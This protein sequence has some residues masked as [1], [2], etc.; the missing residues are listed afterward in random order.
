LSLLLFSSFFTS[1]HEFIFTPSVLQV[2][3][4]REVWGI[5]DEP[6]CW[7]GTLAWKLILPH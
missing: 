5:A 4:N 6:I 2:H 7:Q 1:C 3:A